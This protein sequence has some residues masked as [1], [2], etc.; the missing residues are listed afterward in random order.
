M[1]VNK[2]TN[3][4]LILLISTEILWKS[5]KRLQ[6]LTERLRI[7]TKLLRIATKRLRITSERL[8]IGTSGCGMKLTLGYIRVK[9]NSSTLGLRYHQSVCS[10]ASVT[11]AGV[12]PPHR[13]VSLGELAIRSLS[14]NTLASGLNKV[15][16]GILKVIK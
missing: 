2:T 9:G 7:S 13:Q 1:D 14:L 8:L 12:V 11:K 16:F 5:T 10:A 6:I 4:L 15:V 3:I